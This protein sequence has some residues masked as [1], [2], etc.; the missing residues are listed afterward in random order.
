MLHARGAL[1]GAGLGLQ[2]LLAALAIHS[3]AIEQL[4]LGTINHFWLLLQAKK[5]V[6]II[7]R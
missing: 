1:R 3:I 2:L 7:G 4:T 6:G 5:E